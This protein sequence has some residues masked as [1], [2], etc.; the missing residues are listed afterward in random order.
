MDA[1]LTLAA[2]GYCVFPCRDDKRPACP[3]GFKDATKN[4]EA[5]EE[6]WRR[7][8][9]PLIGV[10]TGTMS[11]FAVL[12]IDRKH[13]EAVEWWIQRRERL[14]PTRVHRTRS[15]GLHLL[16]RHSEG[17]TCSA[18][19]IAVGIDVRADGGYI[20][21]WPAAGMPVL[22]SAAQAPWPDWL[23]PSTPQPRL[24]EYRERPAS[25]SELLHRVQGVVA[26]VAMAGEGQR[27]TLLYWGAC[28]IRDMIAECELDRS[29]GQHA[30]SALHEAARRAGLRDQE[31]S[32]TLASA[33]RHSV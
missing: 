14:M 32:R 30:V 20:V 4:A 17:L 29:A 11:G 24:S 7:F 22:A 9:G 27:N 13:P 8:S 6:L 33:V 21:W 23:L 18:S 2:F 19:K 15:G 3:H 10:A 5:I 28:R 1:A 12:D 16:Y 31:I 26:A 25:G